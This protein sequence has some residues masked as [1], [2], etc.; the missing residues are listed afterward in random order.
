MSCPSSSSYFSVM[1]TCPAVNVACVFFVWVLYIHGFRRNAS[2][3]RRRTRSDGTLYPPHLR[4]S[5]GHL[6]RTGAATMDKSTT[7][8]R[9]LT[10]RCHDQA[11]EPS[12][13]SSHFGKTSTRATTQFHVG[14]ARCMRGDKL[15]TLAA[16]IRRCSEKG[17]DCQPDAWRSSSCKN[18]RRFQIQS[19][20]QLPC[21]LVAGTC[22][23]R[24]ILC[25]TTWS[26]RA[27]VT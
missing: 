17:S 26:S 18:D 7:T 6:V 20:A 16:E 24:A 27:L 1:D 14:I 25:R 2:V 19:S 13:L 8:Q 11:H 3:L 10:S 22:S 9:C 4:S 23:V 21:A 12:T 5:T 15:Q